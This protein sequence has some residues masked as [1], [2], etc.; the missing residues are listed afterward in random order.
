MQQLSIRSQSR[1]TLMLVLLETVSTYW[2]NA[3]SPA[4]QSA[5]AQLLTDMTTLSP[6]LS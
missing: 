1:R 6:A 4:P 5:T 2:I 3:W